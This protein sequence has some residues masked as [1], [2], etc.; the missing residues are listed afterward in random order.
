LGCKEFYH[1]EG[2]INTAIEVT[3]KHITTTKNVYPTTSQNR[4]RV[5]ANIGIA[6]DAKILVYENY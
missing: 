5:T 6:K 1:C 2:I 3:M 4:I